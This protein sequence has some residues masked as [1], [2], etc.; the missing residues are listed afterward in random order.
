M[1]T[2]LT[3]GLQILDRCLDGGMPP[4]S[5]VALVAPP[6]SQS[7]LLLDA[8]ATAGPALYLTSV[9]APEEVT[10]SMKA[11]SRSID[12]LTVREYTSDDLRNSVDT[13]LRGLDERDYVV[14]DT[15]ERIESLERLARQ[16]VLNYI[17]GQLRAND[18]VGLIHCLGLKK[19]EDRRFT[20]HRADQVWT[21][22]LVRTSLAIENRLYVTKFRGGAAMT[23]PVKLRLTDQVNI[24]TSR[25]IG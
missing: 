16:S 7:E 1:S 2:R 15:A 21:L 11:A 9:R 10:D 20:L 13:L 12:Q 25:D 24:D 6:E 17:K 14:F 8:V 22:D 4:G 23:E 5:L 18:A 3:T 19:D